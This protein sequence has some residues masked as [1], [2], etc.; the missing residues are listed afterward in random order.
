VLGRNGHLSNDVVS[1]FLTCDLASST[2]ALI[3]G[4]LSEHNNHPELVR[5]SAASALE[6]RGLETRLVIAEQNHPSEVFTF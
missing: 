2:M 1:D 3:L 6:R 5:M 4:H